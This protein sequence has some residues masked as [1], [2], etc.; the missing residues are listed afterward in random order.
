V[1]KG[2]HEDAKDTKDGT[3]S[4]WNVL[5]LGYV[6]RLVFPRELVVFF[7]IPFVPSW[8]LFDLHA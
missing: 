1:K 3:R 4:L 8:F 5:V 6:W 7:V 2:H